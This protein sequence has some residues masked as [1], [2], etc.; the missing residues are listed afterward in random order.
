[1]N[2]RIR[3]RVLVIHSFLLGFCSYRQQRL[4][5]PENVVSALEEIKVNSKELTITLDPVFMLGMT[6]VGTPSLCPGL[7]KVMQ[8]KILYLLCHLNAY[9]H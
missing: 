1:M 4:V 3:N 6:P 8:Y 5:P 7:S 9:S 2:D